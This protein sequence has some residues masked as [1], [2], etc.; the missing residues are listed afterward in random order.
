MHVAAQTHSL[1]Y[2][3]W[4][5]CALHVNTPPPPYAHHNAKPITHS[6]HTHT[7][8]IN[9]S[10]MRKQLTLDFQKSTN[11]SLRLPS[12]PIS[13]CLLHPPS[14]IGPNTATSS[15]I[16]TALL[17]MNTLFHLNS[18]CKCTE[19]TKTA[20]RLLDASELSADM[21]GQCVV[22]VVGGGGR[23]FAAGR[24]NG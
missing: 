23:W 14:Q 5:H 3:L 6:Q 18:T 21:S 16:S 2:C 8:S 7:H 11:L 17:S 4:R 1:S 24:G 15:T 19:R 20:A 9:D 22:V 10:R 13:F 12:L